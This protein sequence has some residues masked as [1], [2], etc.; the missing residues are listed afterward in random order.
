[1]SKFGSIIV[2]NRL[3]INVSRE[4]GKLIYTK[5]NGG[6]A[7]A[8]SSL[9]SKDRAW[10][11]WP[12]ISSDE[13]TQ[14]EQDEISKELLKQGCFAVHLSKDEINKFY[15]GYSN[16]TL[17]PLFHYF[18]SLTEHDEDYWKSYKQVNEK[19][20][21]AV[22]KYASDKATVW[23]HDYQLLLLPGMIRHKLPE[24][25]IGFFLHIPF[26]SYEVFRQLPN[27]T[28]IM[29]G[30][31]GADLIGFHIYDYAKHFLSSAE[32][33][34]AVEDSN[35]TITYD[36]RRLV[37]DTFPIGV[38][39]AKIV[40]SLNKLNVKEERLLIKDHY[41]KMKLIVSVD[42]M[43]YTKGILHRLQAYELLL[44][45]HPE[46][47]QKIAL[48][49]VA[50]P[51]RT[52]VEAYKKLRQEIEKSISR[53]NGD[54]GTYNWTPISYQFKNL[55]F[56]K[57]MALFAEAAIALVT[58]L[59]DGM[60]LVAKEYVAANQDSEGVL[61]LS[62]MAGAIDDMPEA[63][64]INPSSVRSM[65][66]AL[67]RAIEM[68]A[69]E[70]KR[71]LSIM[72]KRLKNYDVTDW[73]DDFMNQLSRVKSTQR[74][75]QQKL[76]SP[77][78]Q[79]MITQTYKY[80][81]ER[82]LIFDYDGTLH[83]FIES[84]DPSEAKPSKQLLSIL[85]KLSKDPKTTVCIIS[86][87]TKEALDLWFNHLPIVLIAEH[88]V[89][90]KRNGKWIEKQTSFSE[91]KDRLKA[92]LNRYAKRTSRAKV[93]EKSNS[94]VWHFRRV[95]PELAYA[96]NTN[97]LKDIDREID[98]TDLTVFS[99]NKVIEIKSENINKGV[100]ARN[101]YDKYEADFTL[102]IGDDYTDE[103]MFKALPKQA[104]TINV[105]VQETRASSQLKD[106]SAVLGL[107]ERLAD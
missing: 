36:G 56:Y 49:M 73:A 90:L 105:G 14:E 81:D 16:D 20:A 19:Y 15:E 22:K 87:R 85:T 11:G 104:F 39:Y 64:S 58:P 33:I 13:L 88:G 106:V 72:Q 18:Q 43:D 61:I 26:P 97:L 96:R 100:I 52:G 80:S 21:K 71:R 60:N 34:E 8:M 40:N 57:V 77:E 7:T 92:L 93:E 2:S 31:L 27:R 29:K 48:A 98:D 84:T 83:D 41:K 91:H 54:Y 78:A 89:W 94:L 79:D 10:I 70:Q 102:C 69:K 55:P 17:W 74:E 28:E 24:S 25:T 107:L 68:P 86:G 4:D 44:K 42:R 30:M 50:V 45:E 99:G 46:Y 66:E 76:L 23:V 9:D 65:K 12:G 37:V 6:L 47:H 95:K 32:R 53:I 38:D 67:I 63:L 103:D 101:I 1:L 5:S 35:G 75:Q 59:R 51:S 3:P 82:L 62:E